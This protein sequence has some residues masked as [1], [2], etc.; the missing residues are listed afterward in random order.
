VRFSSIVGIAT[1]AFITA[2]NGEAKPVR[3]DG[4]ERLLPKGF[5]QQNVPPKKASNWLHLANSSFLGGSRDLLIDLDNG[6]L[7]DRS[8]GVATPNN[9]SPAWSESR[10]QISGETVDKLHGAIKA[11]LAA[12]LE[13]EQCKRDGEAAQR[14]GQRFIPTPVADAVSELS[15]SLDGRTS[16]APQLSC[17]SPAVDEIW[18]VALQ[19]AQD[20]QAD[21]ITK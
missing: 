6:R 4:A 17:Q 21:P 19:A 14:L 2:S 16:V 15:V 20:M 10:G 1:V 13:S 9:P 12:G 11:G 3:S 18:R 5:T 8:R 7:V